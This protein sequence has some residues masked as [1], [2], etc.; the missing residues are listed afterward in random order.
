ACDLQACVNRNKYDPDRC[1]DLIRNLYACCSRMYSNHPN[2][3]SPACP[4]PGAI[5]RWLDRHPE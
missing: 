3:E 4:I 5:Q 1:E 2:A